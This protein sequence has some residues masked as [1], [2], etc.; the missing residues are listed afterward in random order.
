M[1]EEAVKLARTAESKPAIKDSGRS[2]DICPACKASLSYSVKK[3]LGHCP[4]CGRS[5]E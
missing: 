4:R 1:G 5:L 2:K 3:N